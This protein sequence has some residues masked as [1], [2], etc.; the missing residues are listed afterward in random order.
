MKTT[1]LSL[2]K[3]VA[4]LEGS[5]LIGLVFIAMPLKYLANIPLGVK[6]IGPIHG[7]LFLAFV[8]VIVFCFLTR[9]LSLPK[10]LI[11]LVASLIPFG[12]FVFKA[13]CL[14]SETHTLA[15]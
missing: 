12:T 2:L 11:G 15:E 14:D 10:T 6:I 13:K 8:G 5:S 9:R 1:P 4:L 7:L 3:S